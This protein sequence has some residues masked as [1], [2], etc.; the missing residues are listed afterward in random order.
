MN[1]YENETF[2]D[3]DWFAG[4]KHG[5]RYK[6]HRDESPSTGS[7]EFQQQ[8][9]LRTESVVFDTHDDV[10]QLFDSSSFLRITLEVDQL[11]I[12][13]GLS[14]LNYYEG[15]SDHDFFYL[16]QFLMHG[17]IE[18]DAPIFCG[19]SDLPEN[20]FSKRKLFDRLCSRRWREVTVSPVHVG[21]II[22][23]L[24]SSL[25]IL[26]SDDEVSNEVSHVGVALTLSQFCA[27]L[28]M[29]YGNMQE[30]PMLFPYS[31][32]SVVEGVEIPPCPSDWP[33][34]E[35]ESYFNRMS[36]DV[37]T[38]IQIVL[39]L[40]RLFWQCSF[41]CPEYFS[42]D[43]GCR[44]MLNS[45]SDVLCLEADNLVFQ[46]EFRNDKVMKVGCTSQGF[47]IRDRRWDSEFYQDCFTVPSCNRLDSKEMPDMNWGLS[48]TISNEPNGVPLQ[49]TVFISPDRN[50]MINVGI[51]RLDSCST[52]LGFFWILLEYFSCYFLHAEFG[53]PYFAAEAMKID[54]LERSKKIKEHSRHTL[55]CL[56]LDVRLWLDEPS[57][58]IPPASCDQNDPVLLLKSHEGGIFYRYRTIDYGFSSQNIVTTNLDILFLRK[59]ALNHNTT[60]KLKS[61]ERDA[62][63]IA[64]AFFISFN[65]EF[66]VQSKHFNISISSLSPDQMN[67][68]VDRVIIVQPLILPPCTVCN[69]A[70][71]FHMPPRSSPLCDIFVTPEYLRDAGDLLSK[72]V[73]PYE[74]CD[75]CQPRKTNALSFAINAH[76]DKLRFVVCEPVLGM[77][78]PLANL[79]I[80]ELKFSVS[81]LQGYEGLGRDDFDF[82]IATDAQ[83]WVDYYKSGPTRSWEPLL[84]PF[85]CTVLFEKSSRRGQGVTFISDC[86]LHVNITGAFLETI[87]FTSDS[88]YKSVFKVLRDDKQ[89]TKPL[90]L[91]QQV[92]PSRA[93]RPAHMVSE[94]ISVAG[95]QIIEVHHEKVH[96]ISSKDRVA[97][98]LA[99]LSGNRLRFH[100]HGK[101]NDDLAVRYLDH[102]GITTLSF[103]P[104]RSVIRNL[105]VVEIPHDCAE[106]ENFLKKNVVDASHFVDIQIPGMTWLHTI[107]VD[108]IGKRFVNLT[109]R[110]NIV[111]V[112]HA[113]NQ[114]LFLGP[115]F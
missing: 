79:Y 32:S 47:S 43:V 94:L 101:I 5:T 41:D 75:E 97:F 73:G 3:S 59:I 64:S 69:P 38:N 88:L 13:T 50:C 15:C 60:R 28:S 70:F 46:V 90:H 7:Y 51:R 25:R 106:D 92:S 63:F 61:S 100:Q 24:P 109:P 52:D 42:R 78:L 39:S 108:K 86:P 83:I 36:T 66:F 37:G 58:A 81:E 114:P 12:F 11:R 89:A 112:S 87:C 44:Y 45:E 111:Q 30:L 65:Y 48:R 18:N 93:L 29:W 77:H 27:F 102:F 19:S 105:N 22:D 53:N 98:S 40:S 17:T 23:R 34:Y 82:Q 110:S 99:N 1:S 8:Y 9:N 56:N 49:L 68:K 91:K 76:F 57:I 85:K 67:G 103:P 14:E 80:S 107:C 26:I 62:H 115:T 20:L 10:S 35:T 96:T 6:D 54:Y 4:K 21:I 55:M 33:E 2:M 72:F 84:E 16:S 113:L 74:Q 104:T 31:L 95:G 71:R